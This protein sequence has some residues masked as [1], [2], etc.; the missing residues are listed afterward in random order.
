M[1]SLAFACRFL[2]VC[3]SICVTRSVCMCAHVG[4]SL[5]LSEVF[6]NLVRARIQS[7]GISLSSPSTSECWSHLSQTTRSANR[8]WRPHRKFFACAFHGIPAP[9]CMLLWAKHWIVCSCTLWRIY[10]YDQGCHS[11]DYMFLRICVSWLSSILCMNDVLGEQG[12]YFD[13]IASCICV[14][15][16]KNILTYIYYVCMHV[17]GH[18]YI[19]TYMQIHTY[20]E[21]HVRHT[22]T[23]HRENVPISLC[24]WNISVL[25][26]YLPWASLIVTENT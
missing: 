26:T 24:S 17:C 9:M 22:S 25:D 15:M 11:E 20:K 13:T 6:R 7:H 10:S 1:L 14:Y 23:M 19:H 12:P 2:H 18:T 8:R 16:H 4:F 21:E 5:S 3:V